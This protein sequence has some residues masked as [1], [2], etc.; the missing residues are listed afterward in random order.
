VARV[1]SV[2]FGETESTFEFKPIDR[3]ALYGKRRRVALDAGGEPCSRASLLD[4]GSMMLMSGMTGQGYFLEDGRYLK[5][6]E[7]EGFDST[8]AP[9]PKAP[10]TL[11]VAQQLIGP[12]D[13]QEVLDLRVTTIYAL[14]AEHI[15]PRLLQQLSDGD[16]F[17]FTFNYREDYRAETGILL[18]NEHGLFALIGVPVTYEW[19]ALQIVAELPTVDEDSDDDLDFEMF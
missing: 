15:D 3:A 16:M 18:N 1:I 4:D 8:G 2:S 14:E 9:L 13:P 11:G 10:S 5:Q 17:R 7:L 6:S 19:S 12:I